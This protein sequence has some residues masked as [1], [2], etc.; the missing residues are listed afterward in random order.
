MTIAVTCQSPTSPIACADTA[1]PL[2]PDGLDWVTVTKASSDAISR[3]VAPDSLA[4]LIARLCT[5]ELRPA[6]STMW[7]DLILVGA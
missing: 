7:R 4:G 1:Q 5:S 2:A 6:P 3:R